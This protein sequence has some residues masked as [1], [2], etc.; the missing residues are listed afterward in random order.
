MKSVLRG[1]CLTLCCAIGLWALAHG[2]AGAMALRAL[3]VGVDPAR[4]LIE[5]AV[6]TAGGFCVL[7][8]AVQQL[9]SW[10]THKKDGGLL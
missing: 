9:Y 6:S 8:V 2:I 7:S 4:H 5:T 3:P 1:L 10:R